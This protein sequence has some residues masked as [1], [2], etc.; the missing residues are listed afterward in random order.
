LPISG[1]E[2]YLRCIALEDVYLHIARTGRGTISSDLL[3]ELGHAPSAAGHHAMV[4]ALADA[5]AAVASDAPSARQTL[6]SRPRKANRAR[7]GADS[8]GWDDRLRSA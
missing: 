7:G 8:R 2:S 3:G 5:L 6:A 4:I 1:A